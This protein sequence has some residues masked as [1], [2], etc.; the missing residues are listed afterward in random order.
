MEKRH[1]TKDIEKLGN[2]SMY[3]HLIRN[4]IGIKP[5]LGSII[6]ETSLRYSKKRS[7]SQ[8]QDQKPQKGIKKERTKLP[9]VLKD[10]YLEIQEKN[11][12]SFIHCL[13]EEGQGTIRPSQVHWIT[14]LK[15]ERKKK[16]KR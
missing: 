2:M 4:R 11:I 6:F 12:N 15:S 14:S 8:N 7:I 9:K 10:G 5:H 13:K 1:T 16:K 3:E